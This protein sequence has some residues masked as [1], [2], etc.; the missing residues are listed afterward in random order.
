VGTKASPKWERQTSAFFAAS[1]TR[2]VDTA[3][4]ATLCLL[5]LSHGLPVP[6]GSQPPSTPATT[7][8][9]G[10]VHRGGRRSRRL[11]EHRAAR[12]SLRG[13]ATADTEAALKD[14]FPRC[15]IVRRRD[16]TAMIPV[17]CQVT[18][19]LIPD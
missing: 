12:G 5:Q 1:H 3:D 2:L 15:A 14:R 10:C 13:P 19:P 8:P 17:D 18:G 7:G 11:R 4:L 9:E 16:R 6:N